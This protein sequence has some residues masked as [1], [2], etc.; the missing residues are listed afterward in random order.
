MDVAAFFGRELPIPDGWVVQPLRYG[1]K[2]KADRI[3]VDRRDGSTVVN[4]TAKTRELADACS[5]ALSRCDPAL[6]EYRQY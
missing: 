1:D 6:A 2:K 5:K 3:Y 4:S